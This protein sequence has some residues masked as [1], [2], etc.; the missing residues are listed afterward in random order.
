MGFFGVRGCLGSDL[1]YG[2]FH[3]GGFGKPGRLDRF[4]SDPSSARQYCDWQHSLR[5]F[6]PDVHQRFWTAQRDCRD[7]SI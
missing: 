6:L 2:G 7:L 5:Q 3:H 1:L 4:D